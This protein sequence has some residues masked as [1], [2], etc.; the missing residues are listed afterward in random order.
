GAVAYR[1]DGGHM[2]EANR[3]ALLEERQDEEAARPVARRHL[4]HRAVA[5]GDCAR[6]VEIV[7][8]EADLLKVVA[9]LLGLPGHRPDRAVA[10]SDG[11]SRDESDGAVRAGDRYV[12]A[13]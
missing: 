5:T 7:Q 9:S 4:P 13:D 3:R 10:A 1:A 2:T 6:I 8:P 12:A 11:I